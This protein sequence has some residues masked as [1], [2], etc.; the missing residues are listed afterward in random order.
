MNKLHEQ[1]KIKFGRRNTIYSPKD[2]QACMD[3]DRSSGEAV[4][5][6]EYTGLKMEVLSWPESA[7]KAIDGMGLEGK[8]VFMVAATLRPETMC[9]Q[10]SSFYPIGNRPGYE[11]AWLTRISLASLLNRYGQTNCFVGTGITYGLFQ[12]SPNEIYLISERAAKNMAFQGLFEEDGKVKK[13]GEIVGADLVG[14]KI[15][16]PLSINKE[17]WVLPMDGVLATKVSSLLHPAFGS[18]S[19]A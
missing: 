16:A 19:S 15:N 8:K 17:V 14:T 10:S 6:Q 11:T 1:K 2:G 4:G 7:Q 3:H 13:L 9:V 5:P 18:P 12:A